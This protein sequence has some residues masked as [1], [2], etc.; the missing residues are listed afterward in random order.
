[1]AVAAMVAAR[2]RVS[3]VLRQFDDVDDGRKYL[4]LGITLL[5]ARVAGWSP[6]SLAAMPCRIA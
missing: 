3:Y 1:M 6:G 5:R 4:I 2:S